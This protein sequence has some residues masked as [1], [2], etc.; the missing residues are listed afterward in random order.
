[1]TSIWTAKSVERECM[2][3]GN[4]RGWGRGVFGGEEAAVVRWWLTGGTPKTLKAGWRW[5]K[6]AVPAAEAAMSAR[7]VETVGLSF[8]GNASSGHICRASHRPECPP[9]T[10][11]GAFRRPRRHRRHRLPHRSPPKA[12]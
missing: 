10:D 1:M 3:L 2:L 9:H 11:M 7:L 5:P 12:P 6:A 4:T 8:E